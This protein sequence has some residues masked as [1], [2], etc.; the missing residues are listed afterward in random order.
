MRQP[1]PLLL[2]VTMALCRS[3]K[4]VR[5]HDLRRFECLVWLVCFKM[6]KVYVLSISYCMYPLM[7]GFSS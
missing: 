3:E 7:V 2:L 4:I 5:C 6:F 1:K